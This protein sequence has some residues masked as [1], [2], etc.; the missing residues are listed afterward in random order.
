MV[1]CICLKNTKAPQTKSKPNHSLMP[2]HNTDPTNGIG[3]LVSSLF[4][5]FYVMLPYQ[6]V[7]SK[8]SDSYLGARTPDVLVSPAESSP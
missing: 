5:L 7:A 4:S 6:N 1:V 3:C 2:G 8:S